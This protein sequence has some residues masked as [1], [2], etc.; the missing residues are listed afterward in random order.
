MLFEGLVNFAPDGRTILPGAAE[1]WD[2]SP[3]G[4][5]YTFHLR[6]GLKWSNGDPL[7]SADFLYSFRRIV[8]PKLG[9]EMAIY[10][11][12]VVGAEDYREG[13]THDLAGIG[14]RAPDPLTFEMTLRERAPFWLSLLPLPPFF[15]VHRPTIEKH[16][17]YVRREGNWTR[18][19][20]M[21]C[22][23][24]FLLKEWRTNEFVVAAKNPLYWDAAHVRLQQVVFHP[25]ENV[26]AEEKAFRGGLLHVTRFLPASKLDGYRHPPSPLLHTDPLVA[27]KFVEIN[28]TRAPFNDVRVR[29]AFALALDREALVQN[30]LRDGSR[31]A[32]SLCVPGSGPTPGYT[33]RARLACDPARART[34]L[35]E[36]GFPRG[37][38]LPPVTL[39]FSG[40]KEGD[41]K[42]CE[43]MQGMWQTELGVHVELASQEEK[44]RLDSAR[45]KNYQLL[46]YS[47]QDINDPVVLLQLFLGESPNNFTGW[48]SPE[49]DREFAAAGQAATDADRWTHLQ[50]ADALLTDALPLIPLYHIN[51]NY[52]VQ[53]AVRGWV[54]NPLDQHPSNGIYLDP[55][56]K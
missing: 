23:G 24:P 20:S 51:Q 3:D 29:Q 39:I 50:N 13:K 21:V 43:A 7:T 36:A 37:A 22:N 10:A 54:D 47:W 41:Q 34:L 46:L 25:I 4:R 38:G 45:T 32:A 48:A 30:V 6:P 56:A 11:D 31:A 40:T 16:D 2:V 18:P 44:V 42:F 17:A 12:W 14:F 15:P 5:T 9:S 52:L 33:P 8:E 53:P 49:F 1:R 55:T 19:E 26:D 35:A 27:T 28:V